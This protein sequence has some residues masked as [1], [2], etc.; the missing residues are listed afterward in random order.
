M[1]GNPYALGAIARWLTLVAFGVSLKRIPPPF[2]L[3]GIAQH[4]GSM[5]ALASA[6]I[7]A[8]NSLV[9]LWSKVFPTVFGRSAS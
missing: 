9:T 7:W 1:P 4:M 5:L 2:L 3:T 8:I 6:S